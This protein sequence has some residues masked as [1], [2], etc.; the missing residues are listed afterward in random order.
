MG[1][2]YIMATYLLNKRG[3]CLHVAHTKLYF[4]LF[5]QRTVDLVNDLATQFLSK[6]GLN[7]HNFITY[8]NLIYIYIYIM[9]T[10]A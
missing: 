9:F 1:L 10:W 8:K 3:F 5:I 2:A 7:L 6:R 4:I